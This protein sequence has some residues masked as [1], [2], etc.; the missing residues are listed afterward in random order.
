VNLRHRRGRLRVA[1]DPAEAELL[2]GL[3]DELDDILAGTADA[4]DPVLQRL[5]P[6]A[7][8]DDDE[9]AVE[10][11]TMTE[12]GL[13]GERNARIATCRAELAEPGEIDLGEP[14]A[15][16]RWIQVLNDLRLALGTRLE[17]SEDDDQLDIDPTDPAD[18]PR[19]VYHWL[20][21][22]QD[23]LVTALMG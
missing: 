20:S 10:F 11:R 17:V 5:Y 2:S 21:A 4:D 12:S 16:T 18:R 23:G 15:A 19:L 9:A 6:A 14:E 13:R 22:V 1:F 7:Y 3:L 8:R